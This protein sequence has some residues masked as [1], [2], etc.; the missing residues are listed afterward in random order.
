MNYSKT[1]SQSE[2]F[3]QALLL[4]NISL[5]LTVMIMMTSRRT[6]AKLPTPSELL[7]ECPSAL[8]PCPFIRFKLHHPRVYQLHIQHI[9]LSTKMH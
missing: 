4:T 5:F 2:E 9:F 1:H 6:G 7:I 8:P 3:T